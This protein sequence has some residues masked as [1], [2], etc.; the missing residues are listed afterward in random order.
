MSYPRNS[1]TRADGKRTYT[2]RGETFWS[3]T[4]IL[5]AAP[6]G[7]ALIGWSAKVT[8]E[9]AIAAVQNGTLPAM[10]AQDAAAAQKFLTQSR[11]TKRDAAADAGTL[12]HEAIE[13]W[14]LGKPLPEIPRELEGHWRFFQ[15]WCREYRPKWELSEA[16]VY[17][18][19][20]VYA[21]TLDIIARIG[22]ARWLIDGK[23]S[24][25]VYDSHALQCCA[26][27]RGE[28]VGMPDGTEAELP[29]IHRAGVLLVRPKSTRLV[30][31]AIDDDVFRSFLYIREVFRWMEDIAPRVVLGTVPPPTA[32]E[33]APP[34]AGEVAD[35]PEAPAPIATDAA[36]EVAA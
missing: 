1:E 2:W 10:V 6:K 3:V 31:V 17:N 36:E 13:A 16:T 23:T 28:F 22:K 5:K 29:E 25:A 8:A 33:V 27:T 15:Q 12:I 34:A 30:E 9:A 26:Y 18:R 4:T 21:G 19:S 32:P 14:I 20:Q 7:D 11:F 35:L 24:K